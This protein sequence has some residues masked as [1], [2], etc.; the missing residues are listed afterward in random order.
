MRLLIVAAL[1]LAAGFAPADDKKAEP[2]VT[3]TGTVTLNGKPLDECMVVFH[4]ADNTKVPFPGKTDKDG[5]YK[6]EVPAGEY[7]VA[8]LKIVVDEATKKPVT[9]TPSKYAD[10]KTSGIKA[11]VKGEKTT[12][13]IALASK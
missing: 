7:T 6:V 3:V 12:F 1:L 8:C 11:A 13:D 4:P 9:V 10:P 5:K 2:K